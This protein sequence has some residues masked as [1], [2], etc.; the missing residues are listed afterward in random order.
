[1]KRASDLPT[2]LTPDQLRL[3]CDPGA[4]SFATTDE[5]CESR[6]IIG[7][8]RAQESLEFG[9]RIRSYGYNVFALGIPGTGKATKINEFLKEEAKGKPV[10]TD[11]VYVTNFDNP[12]APN[13]IAL[14]PGCAREL[15]QSAD[16]LIAELKKAI[17]RAFEDREYANKKKEIVE[18]FEHLRDE[19]LEQENAW[20]KERGYGVIATP[21]GVVMVPTK[22]GEPMR[23]EEFDQ[24][25]DEAK[26]AFAEATG[27]FQDRMEEAMAKAR[28]L[29]RDMKNEIADLDKKVAAFAVGH[30]IDEVARRFKDIPE[31]TDHFERVRS[32]ILDNI[33][34]I[35]QANADEEVEGKSPMAQMVAKQAESVLDSYGVN[36]MV[37]NTGLDGAPV[38][39]EMSPTYTNLLGRIG[40]RF[41]MGA[42]VSDFKQ[43]RP[44]ALHRANGG[45][46]LLEAKDV[47]TNP[48]A[49][50]A[51]KRALKNRQ[52]RTE[53]VLEQY[54]VFAGPTIEPE[55]IPLDVKV[56]LMG[57]PQLYYLLASLDEDFPKLFKVKADFDTQMSRTD[58]EIDNYGRFLC[59]R[60]KDEGLRPFDRTAVAR[61]VE[62]G[63]RLV[64]DQRKLSSRFS[65]IADLARE[66][67]YWAQVAGADTVA[68]EHV[69][70]A[71]EHR[72]YRSNRIEERVREMIEDGTIMVDVEGSVVGQVNGLSVLSLGDYAFGKPSRITASVAM[73]RGGVIDIEREVKL[74]GPIHSKGVMIL[75][76]YLSSNFAKD[77][78]L[79]ISARLCFEQ[80]YEGVEGDSASCA[81]LY[82][83]LSAIS[84]LP[85]RQEIAVTG[86]VNQRGRVQAIGGAIYKIEG[87]YDV[88]C[89]IVRTGTQGVMI[90]KSNV[91]N[92]MLRE[93]VVEAVRD[94]EFH[95]YSVETI[96]QGFELLTGVPAGKRGKDGKYPE[97]TAFARVDSILREMAECHRDFAAAERPPPQGSPDGN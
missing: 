72:V 14:P 42:L 81:E 64:E 51:L 85:I 37:D 71:I 47:L 12:G 49:W 1:M 31:V 78:P 58:G 91:D 32:N 13:A 90:P 97:G 68:A 55:P 60:C 28:V 20:A 35:R 50:D 56:V 15:I 92:L 75:S 74:A 44:G 69:T 95:V 23:R 70:K 46:L 73:G 27:E 30:L 2:E 43:I 5:L 22:N 36:C 38:V 16:D 40:Q 93:D 84:G 18:R 17:P 94:G 96:E 39:F 19:L 76:G 48:F 26:E 52:I 63:S 80:S 24:L 34:K 57:A 83:L 82:A 8:R 59:T 21:A 3:V 86:S 25:P 7:Q 54:R 67:D 4:L 9:L 77:V 87:Y 41:E 88:C 62:Y 10:P 79:S 61:I 53:D 11:W 29:E 65:D 89:A 6:E 33:G 66:A 45:Y